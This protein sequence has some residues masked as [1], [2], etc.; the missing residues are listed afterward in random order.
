MNDSSMVYGDGLSS[1]G[2]NAGGP[3][4]QMGGGGAGGSGAS[5]AGGGRVGQQQPLGQP[6]V[7]V[8]MG[9]QYSQMGAGPAPSAQFH[10]GMPPSIYASGQQGVMGGRMGP[11]T[12]QMPAMSHSGSLHHARM[13]YY[14]THW[15]L[16]ALDWTYNDG[17]GTELLGL[18]SFSEDQNNRL[19]I[20]QAC[21]ESNDSTSFQLLAE[22]PVAYPPTKIKWEPRSDPTGG[23]VG[24]S[25]PGG[26]ATSSRLI[27]TGDCL[28]L[29]DYDG[30]SSKLVQRCALLNK[31]KSEYMPPLT[32]F[33]WNKVDPSLVVTSSI[34]TTCTIWDITTSSARTQ[35]I[36]HDSE[37]YDVSFVA[38]SV[39]VFA[40]VGADG[41]VRVFDL[42]SL[43]HSTIIYEPTNPVPLLRIAANPFDPNILAT[44][45]HNSS[46]IHILDIRV[47]GVPLTTLDGHTRAVNSISWAPGTGKN[48]Y[49][50]HLLASSG[51]DCQVLLWDTT[52]APNLRA[53]NKVNSGN[54]NNNNSNG[55]IINNALSTNLGSANMNINNGAPTNTPATVSSKS[56]PKTGPMGSYTDNL[57]VNN[58]A[59]SPTADWLALVSGRGVQAVRFA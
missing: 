44:V 21:H 15:S 30:E 56:V 28:R 27:S 38:N 32:S 13:A 34:D 58:I 2:V 23:A 9:Q 18:A 49:K 3:Y 57:E 8:G 51:D 22:S 24:S 35:L 7:G 16:Y 45:A 12:G 59:W 41:S 42:R 1:L 46:R 50:R 47:P 37:V 10:P 53:S 20:L 43:D 33:D 19:Q 11:G 39:D 54:N 40:S 31:P 52:D 29:W 14:E 55:N 25:Q 4:P 36:A 17:L 6:G 5:G 26:Q 48:G